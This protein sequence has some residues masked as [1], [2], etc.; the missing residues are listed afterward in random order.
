MEQKLWIAVGI[1]AIIGI[2]AFLRLFAKKTSQ[3]ESLDD[4]YSRILEDDRF[5]VK[6]RF[7]Q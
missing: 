4:E 2:I 3:A 5:K 6:G 7:E 1:A